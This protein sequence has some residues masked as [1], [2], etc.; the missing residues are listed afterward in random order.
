[1][2][3]LPLK[4]PAFFAILILSACTKIDSTHLGSDLIPVVDNVNTFDTVLEVVANNYIG[5]EE[6]RL[7]TSSPH[8]VGAIS[9]D[10]Q[11]GTSRATMFFEMKPST[12]PF[13]FGDSVKGAGVGFDS[14]VLILDYQTYYGDS[15][16]PVNLKLYQLSTPI[17]R[18]SVLKPS[19]DLNAS[20]LTTDHSILWGSTTVQANR[21]KDSVSLK[22]GPTEIGKV[23]NQ[24][25]IRLDDN[26]ARQLFIADTNFYHSDSVFKT[27]LPGFI[28]EADPSAKTLLYLSLRGNSKIEFYYRAN[29]FSTIK[30][31]TSS[32]FTFTPLSGHA[33]KFENNRDGAEVT[34][35]L[36]PDPVN[37]N[38][39]IFIQASPGTYARIQIPGLSSFKTVNRVI[40]RAELRVTQIDSSAFQLT[41]P[42]ALYL[43]VIDTVSNTFKGVPYDLSPYS[44]YYC[45]P[46]SGIDFGYFGGLSYKE[47]VDSSGSRVVYRFNIA[48]Y[49]QAVLTKGEPIYDFRLSAPFYVFYKNCANNSGVYPVEVFPL[50][51][52]T[53]SSS[54]TILNPPGKGRVKLAGGSS[55]VKPNV[56]MQL[57]IIYSR[58]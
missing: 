4:W 22:R 24:V 1:M 12:Y 54:S 10:P 7:N 17:E 56:R 3:Q 26:L 39:N 5:N 15:A 38:E 35:A 2:N 41:P 8:V 46:S 37:G 28:L 29:P 23:A 51:V 45:F 43:D 6:Y 33:V 34:N 44:S 57:R 47:N 20:G 52:A 13:T 25:R 9:E 14:A 40:H 30:D 50:T 53:S 16:A 32:S 19:Y 21:F 18:D 55:T 48:R 31:T 11:F 36:I 49:L 27:H 58:L 42:P